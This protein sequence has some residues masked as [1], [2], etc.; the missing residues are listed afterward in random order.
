MKTRRPATRIAAL[1]LTAVLLL[2]VPVFLPAEPV[3]ALDYTAIQSKLNTWQYYFCRTV[4]SLALKD[5]YDTGVLASITAGQSFYEGGCAGAPIS[6]IAQNHFGIKAYSNWTGKVYDDDTHVIYNSY[7]DVVNIMGEEYA[8]DASLWRAYDSWEEGVADHS[9]LLLTEAKYADFLTKTTYEEAAYALVE[10]GYAASST[11]APNLIKYI[12]L[13]GFDQLDSVTADENGVFGM[14]MDHS[15]IELSSDETF[16]LSAAAYPAP[17]TPVDVVWS[18]DR[19]DVATVDENGNVTAHK[20]GYTLITAVYNNKEACCVVCVDANGYVM[21]KN[22]AVFSEPDT[23]SD[24]LGKLSRGQPVR[25]NSE[26]VYTS[27]DGTKFYAVSAG[28]GSGA[29]ISG[30]AEAANIYAGGEVRLS[31]GTPKTVYHQAVGDELTVPLEIY[32][33]EIKE[34]T[35][36]WKSSMP[37]VVSVTQEGVCTALTEGVAVISVLIDDTVALTVTVYVGDAAYETLIANAAVYLREGPTTNAAK[38]GVIRAGEEVKLISEPQNGW[39][40]I[41]AVIDGKTMQGYSYS[42]YFN[43]PGEESSSPESSEV[44]SENSS[45]EISS[46]VSSEISSEVSSEVSSEASSETSSE[47]SAGENEYIV[48]YW[49]GKVNV[50]D[51]LNVRDKAGMDGKRIARLKNDAEVVILDDS[52]HLPEEE[53]YKDWYYISFSYGGE[54]M[55]GY[56]C[57]EFVVLT[58]TLDVVVEKPPIHSERY[59]TNELYVKGILAGTTT[60]ALAGEF[61]LTVRIFR[62]EDTELSA[63]DTL[64]TGDTVI[65]YIGNTPVYT[66]L[67]AVKGDANGDGE[68]DAK[69][70]IAV[71]RHVLGTF[72]LKDAYLCAAALDDD[73]ADA[74]DYMMIKRVVLGTYTFK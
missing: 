22:L 1:L 49:V 65:F 21:N 71:K 24:S 41:L 62:T 31:I 16:S 20:Q 70:Y 42:R 6:I 64:C 29:P 40:L 28:V 18:S 37:E 30:Y 7:S 63:E 39:Y 72:E 15:R 36:T 54:E 34:K 32:A 12:E 68:V 26:T 4:M 61:E 58:G 27:V 9:A 44:T 10:A 19:P 2:T 60:K 73:I 67:A 33:E 13:Y 52:I 57:A 66:R 3:S 46:E 11:Y 5:S 17:Q 8:D 35:L 25:I 51:A 53:V 23:D 47:T 56:V 43:R 45:S 48:T 38:L 74:K 59:P 14:I 50:D 69:D 55:T